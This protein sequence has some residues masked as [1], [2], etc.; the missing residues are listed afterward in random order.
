MK[1]LIKEGT[2]E[3]LGEFAIK[4]GIDPKDPLRWQRNMQFLDKSR[5]RYEGI[6]GKVIIAAIGIAVA[7]AAQAAWAG[8]KTM[9]TGGSLPGS[10]HG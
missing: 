1:Q 2:S 10:P 7:G 5:E 3:A 6:H 9:V 8:F 4:F